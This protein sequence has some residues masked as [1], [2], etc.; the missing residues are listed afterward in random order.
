MIMELRNKWKVSSTVL[1]EWGGGDD[2]VGGTA[3]WLHGECLY[4]PE[5]LDMFLVP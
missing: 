5:K 2:Q 4:S 3:A 1:G